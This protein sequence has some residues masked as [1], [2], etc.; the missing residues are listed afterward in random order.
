MKMKFLATNVC[1]FQ[2]VIPRGHV[3]N[4]LEKCFHLYL[5]G[6]DQ[7]IDSEVCG[8]VALDH[9]PIDR[10]QYYDEIVEHTDPILCSVI[11]NCVWEAH[12]KKSEF[13]VTASKKLDN[14]MVGI[15]K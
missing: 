4:K 6:H 11:R 15:P 8:V 1:C 2:V 3:Y 10:I 13:H 5:G 12:H 7:I 14:F 9:R